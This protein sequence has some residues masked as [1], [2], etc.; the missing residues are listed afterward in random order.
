MVRSVALRLLV[1]GAQTRLSFR[2]SKGCEVE[3]F[4]SQNP[5]G[6]LRT[7]GTPIIDPQHNRNSIRYPDSRKPPNLPPGRPRPQQPE[8]VHTGFGGFELHGVR[9]ASQEQ[10]FGWC[11][12][13]KPM[14]FGFL[15]DLGPTSTATSSKRSRNDEERESARFA[16]PY[17]GHQG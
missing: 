14:A 16:K 9:G 8:A 13:R 3:T 6:S 15:T 4:G 11:S 17:W 7:S 5:N 1:S 2:R 12:V 10:H